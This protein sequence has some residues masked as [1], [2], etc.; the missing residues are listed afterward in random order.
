MSTK[1]VVADKPKYVV[2]IDYG[3]YEGFKLQIETD[4][5]IKATAAFNNCEG[6]GPR[7]MYVEL[8]PVLNFVLG[9]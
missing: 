3:V 6:W 5:L 2:M 8:T 4:D 1:I 7:H 9:G